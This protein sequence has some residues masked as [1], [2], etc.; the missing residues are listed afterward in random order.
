MLCRGS[1]HVNPS[2]AVARDEVIRN[3]G[4]AGR[5]RTTQ[6]HINARSARAVTQSDSAGEVGADQISLD[7]YGAKACRDPVVCVSGNE[8]PAPAA[9]PPIVPFVPSSI[10]PGPP[11]GTAIVPVASVP[12]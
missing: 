5:G 3:S 7:G 9:N 1:R 8:V 12:T 11:L 6:I 10:T 2:A 4:C